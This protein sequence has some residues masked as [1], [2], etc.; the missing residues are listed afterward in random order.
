MYHKCPYLSQFRGTNRITLT[1]ISQ[2][3]LIQSVPLNFLPYHVGFP[4]SLVCSQQ[5]GY[6]PSFLIQICC[7]MLVLL[8]VLWMPMWEQQRPG[9]G[10]YLPFMRLQILGMP[11]WLQILRRSKKS[12]S[13]PNLYQILSSWPQ[14]DV[15][16]DQSLQQNIFSICWQTL[17]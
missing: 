12:I 11:N 14:R 8:T 7:G 1:S 13:F 17:F 6:T 4:Y 10:C 2:R 16:F 5:A 15:V 9:L 3:F